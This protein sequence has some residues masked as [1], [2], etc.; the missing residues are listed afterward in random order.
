[1]NM[2]IDLHMH[3]TFSDGTLTPA[4]LIEACAR[5]ELHT[6][7]VTDHDTIDGVEEAL[8]AGERFG[9]RVLPAVEMSAGR[10]PEIHI[11]GYFPD[12]HDPAVRDWLDGLRNERA[13]RA[14]RM[15]A[16]LREIGVHISYDDVAAQADSRAGLGRT[17]VARAL[18]MSGYA[19][20]IQD[21]F[22]RYLV[23]G[24]PGYIARNTPPPGDVLEK[25]TE[26]GIVPVLA[27][28]ALLDAPLTWIADMIASLKSKGLR[29]VECYHTGY[30]RVMERFMLSQAQGKGL[31]VTGGSDYHGANRKGIL[32]GDGMENW[33]N[34]RD[35]LRL[36]LESGKIENCEEESSEF[37]TI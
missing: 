16:R 5:A 11:L 33:T 20:D 23:P 37:P 6:V 24:K 19:Q 21:A 32:P 13:L 31:L 2:R 7:A 36:L 12:I 1:M 22:V 17:H 28:G 30:D 14:A 27:H 15:V 26:F 8:A 25:M 29:G 34:A 18:V 10:S 35:C 3:T 9:V 4:E